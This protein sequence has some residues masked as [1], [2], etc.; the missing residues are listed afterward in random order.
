MTKNKILIYG[1]GNPGRGDDGLGPEFIS[2]LESVKF[3]ELT[4]EANYHLQVEDSVLF[5]EHEL[6]IVVDAL[7]VGSRPFTLKKIKPSRD[8]SF[9]THTVSP[10]VLA[11]L[12]QNLYQ[13]K[14]EVYVLG[15][16]GYD[17]QIGE[18]LSLKARE[19]LR[20]A[21]SFCLNFLKE[22]M[23]GKNSSGIISKQVRNRQKYR[24]ETMGKEKK[25]LLV[26][27]DILGSNKKIASQIRKK[28]EEHDI[29]AINLLS[30]P[31]S[32][33]TSLLEKIGLKL[34]DNYRLGVIEGDIETER[35]AERIR[36]IGLPAWQITTHGACH[37]EA[38]ML[39]QIFD[40]ISTDLDFLFI[41]NVGNLVC[42]ASFDL[43]EGL[44]F[45]LL[46]VPE[47]DDKPKKYPEAFLTSQVL[48]LTK[49]DLLPYLPFDTDRVIKEALEINPHLK[50]FKTSATTGEG[51]DELCAFLEAELKQRLSQ[52]A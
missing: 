38:K 23:P 21:L 52:H 3:P 6:V 20:A 39:A 27:E 50:V 13:K 40:Q 17:F 49:C 15:I 22:V 32:G 47:G 26:L 7:K 43:G 8:Y 18:G 2:N 33:K 45:V 48:V 28:L 36:K 42:P 46:S 35:D 24:G 29:L 30:A 51:L 11:Y 16:R 14:P 1:I 5:S 34:K 19:N 4:L 10:E 44:R 12:S 9:S 37:L 25:E 31:G 41:E